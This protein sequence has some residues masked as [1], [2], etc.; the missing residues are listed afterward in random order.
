M[1]EYKLCE[2]GRHISS[3][4]EELV[5]CLSPKRCEYMIMFGNNAYCKIPLHEHMAKSELENKLSETT[6]KTEGGK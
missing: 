3:F 6:K 1:K 2:Y 4:K 5:E